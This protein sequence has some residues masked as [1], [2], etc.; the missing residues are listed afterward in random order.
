MLQPFLDKIYICYFDNILVYSE[1]KK[2]YTIYIKQVLKVFAKKIFC[3]KLSK[4]NFYTKE[5]VF[6][7]YIIILGKIDLDPEKIQAIIT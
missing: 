1:D 3:L 6:L 2:Q 5:I 7:G 4:Y